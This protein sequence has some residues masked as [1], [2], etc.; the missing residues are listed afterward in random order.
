MLYGH[1]TDIRYN[2]YNDRVKEVI[3]AGEVA[4]PFTYV[5]PKAGH[6]ELV[7]GNAIV[8]GSIT[9]GYDGVEPIVDTEINYENKVA[10]S[11]QYD[12]KTTLY[13]NPITYT[14]ITVQ[15]WLSSFNYSKGTLVSHPNTFGVDVIW[16]ANEDNN[17]KEPGTSWGGGYWDYVRGDDGSGITYR[18]IA[19]IYLIYIPLIIREDAFYYVRVQG[20]SFDQIAS[21][22]AVF[23]DTYLEVSNGLQ[24][25]M[26]A[27]GIPYQALF[28]NH[29]IG[30]LPRS[31]RFV[32]SPYIE[33]GDINT[34]FEGWTVTA[35][36]L[37]LGLTA[38]YPILKNG[39]THSFGIV[40]KDDCGRQCSVIRCAAMEVYLPWYAE[41]P[42]ILLS[43]IALLTFKI[44]HNPPSWATTYEIVYCGNVSMDFFVQ[45]RA[46]AIYSLGD[47]R[48]SVM[49]QDTLDHTREQNMRWKVPDYIWQEGDRMR[50]IAS[51]DD[52]TG[53]AT[54][55]TEVYDYEIEQTSLTQY[56]DVIGGDWLLLQAV[57]H[58]VEFEGMDNVLVEIY[59]PRKGLGV[60]TYYG[61]GMVFDIAT[62][63]YGHKYHKGDI[64]QFI[65]QGK[66]TETYAQ[67]YNT[68]NDAWK[69]MR[70]NYRDESDQIYPFWAESNAPSDWWENQTKLTS[71]GWQF[72][73]SK[74]PLRQ[75]VLPERIRHGGFLITG[76]QINNLAHFTF[77]DYIDFPKKNG[78]IT[79]LR[80]IG[81]TLKVIQMHKETSVYIQRIQT[82]NPDGTEQFTLIDNLLGTQ[83]PME[84]DYGCQHPESILTNDRYLYYW[85]NTEGKYIRSAAN[86]QIPISDIKMKRWFK[87]LLRWIQ[88]HGGGNNLEVRSGA[89]VE[90]NE[91][92]VTF[93][94]QEE[95]TGAIFSESHGQWI[96][97]IDQPTDAYIHL[98]NYFAHIYNQRLY[99]MNVDEGQ[100]YLK[101]AGVNVFAEV[102]FPSNANPGKMKVYNAMALYCDHQME[103]LSRYVTIPKEAGYALM[104]TYIAV[105]ENREGVYYGQILKDQ[106]TPGNFAT[107]NAKTMNGR[108]MRGRYCL[109]RLQTTEHD[110]KVR[111]YSAI[112]FSTDSE[113][114]Y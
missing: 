70:L 90:H 27:H 94:V 80:E 40:Y 89:N 9:E 6:L 34:V 33:P 8:F 64:D 93:R 85:D 114:S 60:T 51:I 111:I 67:V 17:T 66:I 105:W 46:N 18:N 92:W 57:D 71:Q 23:G 42:L 78:A 87:D 96:A 102:Q 55:Y 22:V 104:E 44:G 103:S 10:E 2:F 101:W 53:V 21:Y 25:S 75:S 68:A 83:R 50:L 109:I 88:V 74:I 45:M 16:E 62:N 95:I 73:Y 54:E 35:Y 39:A 12:L 41:D 43:T 63:E 29:V 13:N 65:N 20:P 69:Y 38:K 47:D 1:N 61:T 31:D 30:V 81:F 86:G 37:D 11:T 84:D 3:S 26:A 97:R 112:V 100:G 5:P 59:R 4:E 82:F 32:Q 106:N 107:E 58:P 91:I 14:T 77:E 72:L 48:Y 108:E 113:R 19:G 110:E 79:G 28:L 24:A 98:G 56:G 76:T 15:P 49:I 99:I 52:G 36:I 7:C